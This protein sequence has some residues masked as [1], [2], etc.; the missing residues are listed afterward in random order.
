[1]AAERMEAFEDRAARPSLRLAI[2]QRLAGCDPSDE[3]AV[4]DPSYEPE[5]D[6]RARVVGIARNLEQTLDAGN[7][8]LR[9]RAKIVA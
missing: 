2:Q 4:A 8:G 1:M 6:L 5:A 9:T 7:R 3:A